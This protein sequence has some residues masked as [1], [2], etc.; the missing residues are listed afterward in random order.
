MTSSRILNF[1][2]LP[3]EDENMDREEKFDS[4]KK[5]AEIIQLLLFCQRKTAYITD[6]SLAEFTNHMNGFH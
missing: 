3:C 4:L 5:G 2:V 1:T 6:S